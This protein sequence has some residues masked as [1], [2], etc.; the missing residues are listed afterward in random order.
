MF[1]VTVF[2]PF[3]RYHNSISPPRLTGLNIKNLL[4]FGKILTE[5]NKIVLQPVIWYNFSIVD[6][7]I[8]NLG[9]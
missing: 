5:R 3:K 2:E 8:E 4:C 7:G 6:N 1:T 9:G